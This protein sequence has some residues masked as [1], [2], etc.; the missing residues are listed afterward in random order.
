[1]KSIRNIRQ[2]KKEIGMN[3]KNFKN[4]KLINKNIA[5]FL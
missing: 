1:M 5:K 2:K 3:Y 4:L